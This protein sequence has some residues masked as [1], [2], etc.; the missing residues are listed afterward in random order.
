[1]DGIPSKL[2]KLTTKKKKAAKKPPVKPKTE[3]KKID[4]SETPGQ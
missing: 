4:I 2:Q 3:V 1:L